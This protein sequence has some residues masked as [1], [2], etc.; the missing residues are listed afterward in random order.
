MKFILRFLIV[1]LIS[2]CMI[3]CA[4]K[5]VYRDRFTPYVP[6]DVLLQS[7]PVEP[8]PMVSSAY[9]ILS[10]EQKETLLTLYIQ[11]LLMTIGYHDA[12]KA[13]LRLWKSTV[14]EKIEQLNKT[15]ENKK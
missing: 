15:Q 5:P 6:D 3:S 13:G 10:F 8:P 12:D 11:D 1:V 2:L 9:S 4:T 14:N 7:Y